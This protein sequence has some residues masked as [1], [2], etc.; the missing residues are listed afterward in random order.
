MRSI[1]DRL[2]LRQIDRIIKILLVIM[3]FL[4]IWILYIYI[5][6]PAKASL[7]YQ[8]G[9]VTEEELNE[10]GIY[11]AGYYVPSTQE[12]TINLEENG[13]TLKHEHCHK[14][15]DSKGKLCV[16]CGDKNKLLMNELECKISEFIPMF[17]Y[18]KIYGNI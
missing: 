13:R 18:K 8:L 12:I 7:D 2:S 6:A 11:L 10:Q 5:Y 4:I 9:E 1:I 3:V 16:D 15:Q 17:V 14:F